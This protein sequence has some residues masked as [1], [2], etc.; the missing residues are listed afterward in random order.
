MKA[1]LQKQQKIQEDLEKCIKNSNVSSHWSDKF[2]TSIFSIRGCEC[3]IIAFV[4]RVAHEFIVAWLF[5][6][7]FQAAAD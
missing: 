7:F 4:R 2:S 5:T 6:C 3:C 1:N